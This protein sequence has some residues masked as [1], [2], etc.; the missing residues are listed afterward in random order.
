MAPT[1]QAAD[2]GTIQLVSGAPAARREALVRRAAGW[3][4]RT[5]ATWWLAPSP[6]AAAVIR[7][8]LAAAGDS[9]WLGLSVL[10]LR[11]AADRLTTGVQRFAL[12]PAAHQAL[13]S[14][15]AATAKHRQALGPLEP[16][17]DSPGLVTFLSSRF[18]ELRRQ[19]LGPNEAGGALRKTDGEEAGGVLA[20][21]YRDYLTALD[22][23]NLADDE[24]S[25]LLATQFADGANTPRRLIVDLPMSLTPIEQSLVDAILAKADEAIIA[26][27]GPDGGFPT[28]TQLPAAQLL[29]QRWEK[30]AGHPI[31]TSPSPL[32]ERT[33]LPAGLTHLRRHLFDDDTTTLTTPEGV[34]VVA[35]GSSHDTAR[36][37]ARR[38]KRLL[39]GGVS[40]SQVVL[41]APS[42][43]TTAPRYAE[44]LREYGVP[45]AVDAS[46]RLQTAGLVGAVLALLDIAADSWRYESLLTLLSRSD[47][48]KLAGRGAAELLVREL[49]IPSGRQYLQQQAA[50]FAERDATT[51]G[52]RRLTE[53]AKLAAP[54]LDL[55]AAACDKLPEEATP[56]EWLDT[57]DAALRVLGH[58]GIGGSANAADRRAADTLEEA[59]TAIE[60]LAGWR[61]RE[62]RKMHVREWIGLIRAWAARLRLPSQGAAEGRV[63]LV[64]TT[65]A[66]G[67]PCEHLFLVEAGESAFAAA[68]AEGADEA[69]L[70]FYE[71]CATPTRS[72]TFAYAALDSAAQPLTPS[73]FITDVERLF[74]KDALRAGERPLLSVID[75]S[76]DPASLREQRID[77]VAKAIQGDAQGLAASA[78]MGGGA[79]VDALRSVDARSRGDDFGP[80]EGVMAS[81]AA[82]QQLTQRYGPDHTWSASQLELMATC[83]F[84]FFARQVLRMEPVGELALGVDYRRRGLVMH[85]ALAECLGALVKELADDQ[86]LRSIP[87]GALTERLVER[88][89]AQ[90][91]DGKL[92]VH[93]AALARIEA[94]QATTWAQSYAD[95]QAKYEND[96]RWR[97]AGVALKPALLEARFGRATHDDG[98][99]DERSVDQELELELPG[100]ETLRIA[101]RIDRIDTARL[102]DHLLF[103]VIDYKTSKS[104]SV[105]VEQIESGKQL[106]PVL[107]ALAAQRL[108][109][110]DKSIPIGA[111]YWVLQKSGY[112]APPAK[113]LPLVVFEEGEAR[114]SDEWLATVEK[115]RT[116]CEAL[117]RDV[118]DGRFPMDNDDEDCGRRCEFRTIC[119]V[120][121]ARSLG[122]SAVSS[123]DGPE[124]DA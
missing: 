20:R 61:G 23:D 46:P 107:Y 67:L 111:G 1:P 96:K 124:V 48:P 25:I 77:A 93:E 88:I 27:A 29:S 120:S 116:R 69:M 65:T 19:G 5:T 3:G 12:G 34:A 117:V 89:N 122:K 45:V 38:V 97:D 52:G 66:V 86:T 83:P 42:L 13:V 63:R 54:V 10:T 91:A 6:A 109:L 35:G 75:G 102:G 94:R 44:A 82:S 49:Q 92:P 50:H 15:I 115:V 98:A 81:E 78:N 16:L 85:D 100:G 7:R 76:D 31:E 39:T 112:V 110:G 40:P 90:V 108:L 104:Y 68:D 71:L 99:E 9:G 101:G 17:I 37:V 30:I 24:E 55:M 74:A 57:T 47:F 106:Q 113:D 119:R 60:N 2:P 43:D 36:R 59:A 32:R 33:P 123:S 84:K 72:L 8:D 28:A 18:R 4:D 41:A 103:T 11:Q 114:P 73:P 58:A 53:A 14:E 56:L 70:H 79:L 62:P 51:S 21:L 121:Q 87:A 64:G 26:V 80:W 22:R 118:R 95:Q 105:K